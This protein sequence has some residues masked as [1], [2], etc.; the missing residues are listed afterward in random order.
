MVHE[1]DVPPGT[2]VHEAFQEARTEARKRRETVTFTHNDVTVTLEPEKTRDEKVD[3][4]Y[5]LLRILGDASY[6]LYLKAARVHEESSEQPVVPDTV[7]TL[8]NETKTEIQNVE[9]ALDQYEERF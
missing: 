2:P 1:I 9:T 5:R 6:D 3:E 7:R 4:F 8:L